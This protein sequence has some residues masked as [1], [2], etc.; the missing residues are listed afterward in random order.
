MTN[1]V[2]NNKFVD[3]FYSDELLTNTTQLNEE[4][5]QYRANALDACTP[6][7]PSFPMWAITIVI[8]LLIAIIGIVV[9]VVV[10]KRSHADLNQP[11]KLNSEDAELTL[12]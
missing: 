9:I 8:V 10:K 2:K 7:E 12:K 4:L 6:S 3:R 1:Y 11:R 5:K